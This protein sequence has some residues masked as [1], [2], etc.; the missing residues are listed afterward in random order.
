MEIKNSVWFLT[1][2]SGMSTPSHLY[3]LNGKMLWA[4]KRILESG[5]HSTHFIVSGDIAA[6]R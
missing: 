4:D 1:H 6:G 3:D 5:I 2:L